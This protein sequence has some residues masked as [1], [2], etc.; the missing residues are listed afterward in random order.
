MEMGGGH[1]AHPPVAV[2]GG[3][4]DGDHVLLVAPVVALHHKLV[5]ARHQ[6]EAIGVVELLADVL[7]KGV[8]CAS[9]G[10]G[11]MGV[12]VGGQLCAACGGWA[13]GAG[14]GRRGARRVR[15]WSGRYRPGEAFA[16]PV[17]CPRGARAWARAARCSCQLARLLWNH[18]GPRTGS[19][20]VPGPAPA[21]R[22]EMP[23]PQRSSGS[24]HSRSHMGPSCGTS[25]VKCRQGG[26]PWVA[27]PEAR[28]AVASKRT[29]AACPARIPT[30]QALPTSSARWL[31]T[32][33][34]PAPGRLPGCGLACL[35]SATGRRASRRSAP[36]RGQHRQ[37]VSRSDGVKAAAMGQFVDDG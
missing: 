26:Q 19:G 30:P 7:A 20:A 13:A 3:R 31:G 28:L 33:C 9:V 29:A 11:S 22:G 5:R 37:R 2:V 15:A 25:C 12:G 23:Q 27:A 21:P 36:G 16:L 4:E 10:V 18:G 14:S 6:R 34:I 8:A 17:A 35:A 24:L 32:A 1:C